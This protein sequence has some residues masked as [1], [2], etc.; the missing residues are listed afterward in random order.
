MKSTVAAELLKTENVVLDSERDTIA[1][2]ARVRPARKLIELAFGRKM[3]DGNT[4]SS[5]SAPTFVTVRFAEIAAAPAGMPHADVATSNVRAA[6]GCNDGAPSGPVGFL[7][8]RTRH[9]GNV[10]KRTAE[11]AGPTVIVAFP[12]ALTHPE[13]FVSATDSVNGVP[14]VPPVKVI[15]SVPCPDVIV[16]FVI[17]H[18]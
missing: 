18:A 16:P 14:A 4:T 11:P 9:G 6:N 2:L 13:A 12:G 5:P 10:F 17:V 1:L 15:W 8:S 3:S 7:V